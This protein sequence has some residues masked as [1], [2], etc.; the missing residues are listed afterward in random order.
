METLTSSDLNA[1]F[2]KIENKFGSI[3]NSDLARH[4]GITSRKL[5]DRYCPSYQT[6]VLTG[7]IWGGNFSFQDQATQASVTEARVYP[8]FPGKR[9]FLCSISIRVDGYAASSGGDEATVWVTHNGTV[10][11]NVDFTADAVQYI[12]AGSGSTAF[13]S[14]I[15]ALQTGDYIGIQ[16][17][18]TADA[19]GTN[20][21][22][23][24][25]VTITFSYKVELTA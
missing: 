7:D 20:K 19:D 13:S 25:A 9:A 23:A 4:A 11:N 3:V 16:L 17:G 10:I 22:T 2:A 8:E 18:K 14:P 1:Q 12:R 6:V 15:A 21:P 5:A 24:R